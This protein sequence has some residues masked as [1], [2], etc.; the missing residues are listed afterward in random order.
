MDVGSFAGGNVETYDEFWPKLTLAAKV[1]HLASLGETEW[2]RR[3]VK[4]WVATPVAF[5]TKAKVK[6]NWN[7]MFAPALGEDAL[8]RQFY[9]IP[10]RK[11]LNLWAATRSEREPVYE[12]IVRRKDWQSLPHQFLLKGVKCDV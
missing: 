9:L 3:H 10:P 1:A 12:S 8:P 11:H 5:P 4:S 6:F 2:S 7:M